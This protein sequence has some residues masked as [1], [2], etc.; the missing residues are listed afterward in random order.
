MKAVRSCWT[1]N[2]VEQMV[3]SQLREQGE[4]E[5]S[6]SGFLLLRVFHLLHKTGLAGNNG[7]IYSRIPAFTRALSA[8]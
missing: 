2:T 6:N 7:V 1:C 4:Q 8:G 3:L 5:S